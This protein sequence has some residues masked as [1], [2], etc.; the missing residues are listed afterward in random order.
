MDSGKEVTAVKEG[1]GVHPLLE[2]QIRP[3][4]N[5]HE[6]LKRWEEA[7]YFQELES[8]LHCGFNVSF[9]LGT[10]GEKKYDNIDRVLFYL[11]V[12]DGWSRYDSF[13]KAEERGS[14]YL[15]IWSMEGVYLHKTPAELRR[16]LARKAFD[17]LCLNFFKLK[18]EIEG[19]E[20]Y[21][22]FWNQLVSAE[23]LLPAIQKF[24]RVE[25]TIFN[26]YVVCNLFGQ[27]EASHNQKLAVNFLVKLIDFIWKWKMPYLNDWEKDQEPFFLAI[28]ARLNK[29]K[30]WTIEVLSL[31]RMLDNLRDH[32]LDFDEPCLAK[33][34]EI[35]RLAKLEKFHHHP[36]EE[37][38]L[39]ATL[40]EA[41]YVGSKS[42]LLLKEHEIKMVEH[43]RLSGIQEATWAKE[44]AEKKIAE[45]SAK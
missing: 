29:V 2:K 38:R 25:K 4:H 35:A 10:N 6:W 23:Q 12:A 37:D 41:C 27:S 32:L 5:W 16:Q 22:K 18:I 20:E 40:E 7:R 13:E 28:E 24:F 39:V 36:V 21:K 45:L 34:K 44:R 11:S 42:A 14:R 19:H 9:E 1:Q 15:F 8:L 26:D 43:K 3:I 17:I 33:L 30:P 31:L